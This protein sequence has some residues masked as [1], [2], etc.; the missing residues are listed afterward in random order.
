MRSF[1][2]G[3]SFEEWSGGEQHRID[4]VDDRNP[5][6]SGVWFALRRRNGDSGLW[7]IEILATFPALK[8]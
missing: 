5:D 4:H 7:Q 8:R 2:M 6:R 1:F 3:C